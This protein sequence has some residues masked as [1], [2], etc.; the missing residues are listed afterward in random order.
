VIRDQLKK[1]TP[2]II[3]LIVLISCKSNFKSENDIRSSFK[4]DTMKATFENKTIWWVYTDS[5]TIDLNTEAKSF[6]QNWAADSTGFEL[7]HLYIHFF[8]DSNNGSKFLTGMRKENVVQLMGKPD[9]QISREGLVTVV[10]Y[11]MEWGCGN[12]EYDCCWLT[13]SFD[14]LDRVKEVGVS[15]S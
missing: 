8:T 2:H 14:D 1:F 15:C 13:I 11:Y 6:F 5:T 3:V 12:P 7:R 4:A 10:E 9:F